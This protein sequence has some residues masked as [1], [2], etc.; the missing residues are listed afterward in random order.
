MFRKV[1]IANRGEIAVRI[2]R[3]CRDLGII[4]IAVY[5]E[6]DRTSLHVR[7]ADEAYYLGPAPS[8][9]SY[10]VI[11]KVIEAAERSK[12]DAI[13]PGYGFLSENPGFAAACAE[14]GI[15]LVGPS[16]E[17]MRMMGNKTSARSL[18]REQGIPLVPGTYRA[19]TS[20]E[21]AMKEAGALG[22][23]V[24]LKASAG[25]GGKGMR[26]VDNETHMA[27]G[28]A[29]AGSEALRAFGDASVYLEKLM[30]CPHHIEIQILADRH[31]N[32]IHLGE[33]ECSLQR[34]H[35]KVIEE[36]PSPIVDEKLRREMGEA[37]IRIARAAHYENAG[38]IEF[39]VDNDKNFYFLE[40]NTRLQVEHGI[41]E[42]VTGVDIVREQFRIAA[43]E[44][45]SLHQEE[46]QMRG[47]A[48]EC[49]VCAEDPDR[50]LPSAGVIYRL[51]E[52]QG[53][54]VRLDSGIYGGWEV[55]IHYDPLLAKLMTCGVDRAQTIAR[56]KRAV[57]E[58]RITG[59]KTN[60]SFLSEILSDHEFEA[61]HIHTRFIE[62]LQRRAPESREHE[63]SA[64][65]THAIAA[66]LAYADTSEAPPLSRRPETA[67]G[68]KLSGRPGFINTPH[69]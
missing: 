68:W 60:L 10:L 3:A 69:R 22:Y 21:D 47:W 29:A 39:L 32:V 62:E 7:L 66:A 24:M 65:H 57:Q 34:R 36:S 30:V 46:M 49:R 15:P 6:P 58:Y 37:A 9:E 23:P 42:L 40:M 63:P 4:P 26:L 59:I 12:A 31:G 2:I 50:H 56:M 64:F 16:A 20:V 25:G 55:S 67:S 33:R 19:L 43:G 27:S 52:P 18:L 38:T 14:A 8:L 17:S 5:S 45:L 48:M 61:G 11:E 41:T 53:P 35:Q 28:F 1:L 54:G 13:P 44:K 51:Q